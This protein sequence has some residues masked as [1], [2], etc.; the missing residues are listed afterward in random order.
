MVGMQ[1]RG[2]EGLRQGGGYR[3]GGQWM[4]WMGGVFMRVLQRNGPDGMY[5]RVQK[6]VGGTGSYAKARDLQWPS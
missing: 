4:G 1:V 6:G 2:N 3:D 5:I